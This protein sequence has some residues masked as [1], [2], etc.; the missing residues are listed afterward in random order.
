MGDGSII[1]DRTFTWDPLYNKL[2]RKDIRDNGPELTTEY[3]YDPMYRLTHTTV[4]D[5]G[6]GTVRDTQYDLDGVGNRVEVI[7]EPD[8]GTCVLYVRVRWRAW[9]RLPHPSQTMP[10]TGY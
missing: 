3:V 5:D 6:G 10:E 9:L 7:G 4:S 2:E 1:D 8:P